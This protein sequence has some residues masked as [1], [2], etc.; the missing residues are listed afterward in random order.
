MDL[1]LISDSERISQYGVLPST[2][3]NHNII[4]CTEKI[5]KYQV[6]K[7]NVTQDKIDEKLC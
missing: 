6:N 2:I 7:H 1:I 3:R 5:K 4:Y